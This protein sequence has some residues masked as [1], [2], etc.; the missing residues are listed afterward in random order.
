MTDAIRTHTLAKFYDGRAVVEELS[1]AAPTGT[2]WG[3][4]G[5]NGA[6]K[7]TTLRMLMG[8]TPPSQGRAEVLGEDC[9]SMTPAARARLGYVAEQPLL[10]SWLRVDELL[11][12]HRGLYPAWDG[13]RERQLLELFELSP[14]ARIST[15]SK[16]QNRRLMLTLALAQNADL[17]LLDEPASGLDVAARRQLLTLLGEFL[18]GGPRTLVL[19]SHIVTDV[20]RIVTHVA[21]MRQGR[22][23]D[24]AP[25]D[26]LHEQVKRVRMPAA[27]WDET[28][29]TWRAARPLAVE[30]RG[31]TRSAT[32]RRLDLVP[33]AVLDHPGVEILGLG[34][35][36]IYLAITG[37]DHAT[38]AP[39]AAPQRGAAS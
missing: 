15:L 19:S 12:F 1:W 16:G 27:L 8:F 33:D 3:L 10:P 28:E 6:G 9:R 17:L 36:D 4:L 13:T 26:A 11:R 25:L 22:L 37:G 24:T 20:E 38:P 29:A 30:S 2:A 14:R 18:S 34:L 31:S 39:L 7:S 5:A 21:F 23:I 35:E 32:V